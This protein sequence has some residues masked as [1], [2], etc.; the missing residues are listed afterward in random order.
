VE[1]SD[2]EVPAAQRLCVQGFADVRAPFDAVR[3]VFLTG[4]DGDF[5]LGRMEKQLDIPDIGKSSHA[6]EIE[7]DSVFGYRHRGTLVPGL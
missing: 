5:A 7:S 3:R 2:A 4:P 6:I 1:K